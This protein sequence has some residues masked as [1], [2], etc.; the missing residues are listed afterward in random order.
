MFT[1]RLDDSKSQ[2]ASFMLQEVLNNL[3]LSFLS[4]LLIARAGIVQD[5]PHSKS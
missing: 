3:S 1:P 5:Q 4:M 2:T